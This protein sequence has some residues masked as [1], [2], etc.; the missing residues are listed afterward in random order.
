MP[1][2]AYQKKS[3]TIK[4]NTAKKCF[5]ICDDGFYKVKNIKS[6]HLSTNEVC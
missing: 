2:L 4:L 5:Y 1:N 6:L 3:V